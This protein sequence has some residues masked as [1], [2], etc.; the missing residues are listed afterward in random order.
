MIGQE[1]TYTLA[2]DAS[3][4][5]PA[6]S[7]GQMTIALKEEW[8]GFI[9]HTIHNPSRLGWPDAAEEYPQM[10][11]MLQALSGRTARVVLVV[12]DEFAIANLAVYAAAY[13]HWGFELLIDNA[14]FLR[15]GITRV[16]AEAVKPTAQSETT[17][18]AP[19]VCGM[20]VA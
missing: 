14:T 10:G 2:N 11:L 7:E 1:Q 20:E 8:V 15:T 19:D 18:H 6:L 12:D 3:L 9:R 5:L 16:P 17:R 13:A 4:T